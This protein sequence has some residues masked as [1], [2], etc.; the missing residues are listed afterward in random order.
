M[1]ASDRARKYCWY[2]AVDPANEHEDRYRHIA[3]GL[4]VPYGDLVMMQGRM[5]AEAGKPD[6]DVSELLPQPPKASEKTAHAGPM[7]LRPW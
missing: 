2:N 7:E 6:L 3:A 4:D 5:R 1:H